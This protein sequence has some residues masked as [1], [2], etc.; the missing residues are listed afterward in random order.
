MAGIGFRLRKLL[1]KGD[2]ASFLQ[3]YSIGGTIALGPFL[4]SV[5]CL[6][7][8]MFISGKELPLDERQAFTGSV[9]YVF[10]ASMILTGVFQLALTRYLA[11]KIYRGEYRSLAE[12]L[13]PALATAQILL[14]LFS[15][16]LMPSLEL[17]A[18]GNISFLALG[19]GV[20]GLFVSMAFVTAVERYKS[21]VFA[22]FVGA[23][24]SA[25]LGIVG[26][27]QF[28]LD[29]LIG[30]YAIGQ[31]IALVLILDGL[32]REFSFPRKWDWGWLSYCKLFPMLLA[33]GFLQNAGVWVDKFLFWGS[34][35]QQG[36]LGFIT[37]P[38]YDSATFLGFLTAQPALVHFFVRLEADFAQDFHR[39]FDE[40]F[41]KSSLSSIED[42][43]ERLRGVLKRSLWDVAKIQ[44][45]LTFLCMFWAEDI[46]SLVSLP[47]SQIGMF[48]SSILASF[49]LVFMFFG[50]ILLL[51]LDRQKEVLWSLLVFFVSNALLTSISISMGYQYFGFGFAVATLLGTTTTFMHLVT[52]LFNVEFVTFAGIKVQGQV[53]PHASLLARPGGEYGRYNPV[54]DTV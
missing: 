14:A 49:F 25:V 3:A 30:G 32:F 7:T 44:G 21:A 13:F 10:G 36:G 46:L 23:V 53:R 48:R 16:A 43:A 34:S 17:S 15:F 28:G 24:M 50:N 47:V 54:K 27:K 52:Q 37:A 33:I 19:A 41:F 8:L 42:A 45:T 31:G 18:A 6:G 35:L 5:V 22:Y 29:G 11:D 20:S 39:Y 26:M 9:V 51:Y 1:H 4:L 38:K 40:V 2:V 12:S